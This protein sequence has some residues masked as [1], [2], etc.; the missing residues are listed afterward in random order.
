MYRKSDNFT[1]VINKPSLTSD[2]CQKLGNKF[3]KRLNF[4]QMKINKKNIYHVFNLFSIFSQLL[5]T[6]KFSQV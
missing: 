3:D 2:S 4:K 5:K 1:N 6:A